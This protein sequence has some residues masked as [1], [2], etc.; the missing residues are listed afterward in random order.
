LIRGYLEFAA[1]KQI[2]EHAADRNDLTPEGVLAARNDLGGLEFAGISP[3]T[4]FA[5]NLNDAATRETALYRPNKA[6]FDEQGGLDA[7]LAEGAVSPYDLVS[8]F[9]V[10]QVAAAYIFDGPCYTV[11]IPTDDN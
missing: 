1:A 10:S 2:L 3:P 5:D 7:T 6:A 4:I 9:D 8:D 11:V